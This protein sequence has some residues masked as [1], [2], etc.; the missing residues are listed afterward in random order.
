MIHDTLSGL[1]NVWL[2][3]GYRRHATKWGEGTSIDDMDGLAVAI[4]LELCMSRHRLGG[5]AVRYLRKQLG[6]T[7]DELGSEF[8]CS[9][10]A[11]A[12]WEKGETADVPVASAR[13]LRLL[14]LSRLAPSLALEQAVVAYDEP[15]PEKLVFSYSAESGWACAT[16]EHAPLVATVKR[17][18]TFDFSEAIA[19][20]GFAG[21]FNFA[22]F[23]AF[24]HNDEEFERHASKL[25]AA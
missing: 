3:N 21:R 10:Q 16:H 14:V 19:A 17:S 12:K 4:A 2:A 23:S 15:L 20:V 24:A 5:A 9:G 13:L 25:S 22:A 6:M 7:Q 11:V 8:G 18:G 1:P